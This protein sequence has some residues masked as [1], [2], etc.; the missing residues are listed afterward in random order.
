M[1]Q[2]EAR[3][4][5]EQ[6]RGAAGAYVFAN[7]FDNLL[8]CQR[9]AKNAFGEFFPFFADDVALGAQFAAKFG[10]CGSRRTVAGIN[11]LNSEIW[12][13]VLHQSSPGNASIEG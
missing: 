10:K 6:G 1:L 5:V 8:R 4:A 2:E 13:G 12:K 7:R 11:S 3:A 9:L